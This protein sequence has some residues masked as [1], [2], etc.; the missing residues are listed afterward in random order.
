MY[1]TTPN[2]LFHVRLPNPLPPR[3]SFKCRQISLHCTFFLFFSSSPPPFPSL[4]LLMT[5]L[6]PSYTMQITQKRNSRPQKE[7]SHLAS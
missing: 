7:K 1:A 5:E 6:F 3:K 4:F 2:C